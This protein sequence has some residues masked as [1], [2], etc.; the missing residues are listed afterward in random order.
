MALYLNTKDNTLVFTEK[1]FK[2]DRNY[3]PDFLMAMGELNKERPINIGLDLD[4]CPVLFVL[5]FRKVH[6]ELPD[7]DINIFYRD[8]SEALR[9]S[10]KSYNMQWNPIKK[11]PFAM[12]REE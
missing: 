11:F 8:R 9:T 6:Q 2:E 7:L 3:I 10:L 1:D 5:Y 4:V 12:P